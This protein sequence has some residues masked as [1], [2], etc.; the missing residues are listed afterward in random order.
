[1]KRLFIFISVV[2][3]IALYV[4]SA[5]A[6][7]NDE[8]A[9]AQY[10]RGKELYGAD[11]FTEAAIAFQRAYELKPSFKILYNIGQVENENGDYTRALDAYTRYLQEGGDEVP[12]DRR[13]AVDKEI[14]RLKSLVGSFR[15][16]GAQDGAVLMVDGRRMGEAP[17]EEP[18]MVKLGEHEV[19]VKIYGEELFHEFVRVAGGQELPIS[20]EAEPVKKDK[21]ASVHTP[22]QQVD[23]GSKTLRVLGVVALAAGGAAIVGAAIT[24]RN[25]KRMTDD[26]LNTCPENMCPP[27]QQDEYDQAGRAATMSTVLAVFSGLAVTTGVV[28]LIVGRKSR[29]KNVEVGAAAGP[30]GAG[31]LITGRF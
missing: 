15:V 23:G 8:A 1:L 6:D 24:G 22:D 20:I 10:E 12:I 18:V 5:V 2:A 21:P 29:E 26:L 16:E 3:T 4:G 9:R 27:D 25:A 19:V 17:F 14:A 7:E 11:K 30:N 31:L 28:L 13:A